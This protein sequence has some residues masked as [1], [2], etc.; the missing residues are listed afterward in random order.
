M[1]LSPEERVLAAAKHWWRMNRPTTFSPGKHLTNP[2]VNTFTDAE[3]RLATAVA[4]L[5]KAKGAA[6]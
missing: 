5:A 3:K 1:S 2:V 6:K 4:A